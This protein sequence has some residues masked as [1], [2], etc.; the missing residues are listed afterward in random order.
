MMRANLILTLKARS[1]RKN[2]PVTRDQKRKF[3]F[4]RPPV[5]RD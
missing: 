2:G 3:R 1:A 4:V 5:M